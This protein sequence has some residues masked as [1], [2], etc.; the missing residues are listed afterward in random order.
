MP[1]FSRSLREVGL[2]SYRL[3]AEELFDLVLLGL[4]HVQIFSGVLG[5]VIR[6]RLAGMFQI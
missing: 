2:L 4:G 1:H 6:Q 5:V 3:M